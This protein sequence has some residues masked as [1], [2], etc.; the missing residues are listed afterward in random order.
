MCRTGDIETSSDVFSLGYARSKHA[1]CPACPACVCM[2]VCVCVRACLYLSVAVLLLRS[3]RLLS[4]EFCCLSL[5]FLC[6]GCVTLC[7]YRAVCAV[8][9][10]LQV[11]DCRD[12]P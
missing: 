5:H 12:V 7:L 10:L 2:C 4:S 1:P 3:G 9:L 6:L 8:L 11:C